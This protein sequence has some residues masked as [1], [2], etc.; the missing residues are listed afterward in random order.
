MK[1]V[2]AAILVGLGLVASAAVSAA[3]AVVS[4]PIN[5][6]TGPDMDYPRIETLRPGTRVEVFGCVN[7]WSWCDVVTSYGERGWVSA[8]YLEYGPRGRRVVIAYHGPSLG[9]PV[10]SF[11]IG[12]YW[13]TYYRNKPWY[14]QRP[15]WEHRHPQHVQHRPP[16]HRPGH[17]PPP[18]PPQ[19]R[20]GHQ[21]P[22]PRR[23]NDRDHR[24][25]DDRRPR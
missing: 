5:L 21:P 19:H 6:R 1:N 4:A 3:P 2:L 18:P 8:A 23:G 16:Q 7:D 13:D 22:P 12:T 24:R 17:Q 9:L 20:P 11:Y 14:A 15:H 25:G 10:V